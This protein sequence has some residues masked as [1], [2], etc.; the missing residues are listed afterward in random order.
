MTL[1]LGSGACSVQRL[2]LFLHGPYSIKRLGSPDTQTIL[3]TINCHTKKTVY[4]NA[5]TLLF[6]SMAE[7]GSTGIIL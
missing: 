6:L 3:C 5:I 7:Y 2:A 1:Y 4:G